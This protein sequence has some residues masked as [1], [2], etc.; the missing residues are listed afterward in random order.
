MKQDHFVVERSGTRRAKRLGC[1]QFGF[2][3]LQ[4]PV[5]GDGLEEVFDGLEILDGA[6]D[7]GGFNPGE[8]S[9]GRCCQHVFEIVR[10]L[11][12]YFV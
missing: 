4:S 3:A 8:N 12:G 2:G 9:H 6:A 7:L 1:F 10:A 5:V 11:Q